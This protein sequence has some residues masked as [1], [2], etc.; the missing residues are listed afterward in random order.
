MEKNMDSLKKMKED[1]EAKHKAALPT[2]PSNASAEVPDKLA[3]VDADKDAEVDAKTKADLPTHPSDAAVEIP[4]ST[5]ETSEVVAESDDPEPSAP[6]KKFKVEPNLDGE[7]IANDM[8]DGV[9]KE[10]ADE[11][12]DEDKKVE[13]SSDDAD[14]EDAEKE[15]DDKKMKE[16]VDA[17]LSGEELSEDFKTKTATIFEAA[18][19]ERVASYTKRLDEKY[20]AQFASEINEAKDKMVDDVSNYLDHVVNEWLESNKVAISHSIKN[21]SAEN[22]LKGIKGL[23]EDCY[24][25][26]P[27]T[28]VD[29]VDS[30]EATNEKLEAELNESLNKNI[31]LSNQLNEKEKGEAI[32][33]AAS[34]LAE[35]DKE[36]FAT[37][38]E[39]VEY[40]NKEDYTSKLAAIKES[41]F[42]SDEKSETSEKTDDVVEGGFKGTE[43]KP[44]DPRMQGYLAALKQTVKN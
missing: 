36:R 24:I 2:H 41:Y 43:D 44:E 16:H 29:L 27:E 12:E 11:D 39:S 13:E 23:L 6:K 18:V 25:D 35:T 37:I 26:V 14:K 4:E 32:S 42:G 28:K 21:E 5:E 1:V 8:A 7:K 15:E 31:E 17:L 34:D 19:T 40:T 22:L 33:S 38:I 3:K 10:S 9:A 20:D 30:L